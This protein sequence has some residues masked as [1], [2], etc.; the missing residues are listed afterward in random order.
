MEAFSQKQTIY[1]NYDT[2]LAFQTPNDNK[3]YHLKATMLIRQVL[4]V[5]DD[6]LKKN[7]AKNQDVEFILLFKNDYGAVKPLNYL[8]KSNFFSDELSKK[9]F[10]RNILMI[11]LTG[12]LGQTF[13]TRIKKIECV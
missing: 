4:S 7:Q 1:L 6:A 3:Y 2:E 9:A 8:V 13:P 5:I 12:N 10:L 11:G